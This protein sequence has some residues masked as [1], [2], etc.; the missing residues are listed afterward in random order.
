V[1]DLDAL[2]AG[3]CAQPDEDTPRLALADF[4]DEQGGKDNQFRA[5]FIRTH[6][7]LARE[8]PWSKPWRTLNDKWDKLRGRAEGLA[9]KHTLPWVAHLKG[10]VRAFYFER[11]LVGELT[12]FSKRFVGEGPSYFAQDP[13]RGVKFVKLDSTVGSV[14]ADALFQCPHLARL[15]KIDLDGSSLTDKQMDGLATSPHL[16]GLRRLALGGYHAFGAPALPNLLKS[17]PAL[18]ELTFTF[19]WQFGDEHLTGLVKCADFARVKLLD[20]SGTGAK[21]KGVAAVL[22]STHATGLTVF[23]ASA[24]LQ[25]NDESSYMSPTRASAKAGLEVAEAVAAA[26]SL[27]NLQELDLSYRGINDA[28]AKKIAGA[29]AKLP[30]LRR[31]RLAGCNLTAAGLTSLGESELGPR[32]L[33]LNVA[34]NTKLTVEKKARAKL[35]KLFPAAHLEESFDYAE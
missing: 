12:L 13:I 27:G 21:A 14:G 25:M 17:L 8:E 6:C 16:A 34:L 29:A 26:T 22:T 35:K 1:T 7:Q 24:E 9:A 11:G 19:N 30:A 15:A 5:D 23:K 4:L 28:G 32:L 18:S 31:L 3:I 33:Y 2:Y 10:R 20:V